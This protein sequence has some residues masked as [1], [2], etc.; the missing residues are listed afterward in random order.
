MSV[1][2]ES[3]LELTIQTT[4]LKVRN[5]ELI[6]RQSPADVTPA[7]I[8]A[9]LDSI[10]TL[11]NETEDNP[12]IYSK[13]HDFERRILVLAACYFDQLSNKEKTESF[14]EKLLIS[15]FDEVF[16][17][18]V[19]DKRIIS[20]FDAYAKQQ[21]KT[22]QIAS[23]PNGAD[24]FVNGVHVG[25]TP[26]NDFQVFKTGFDL[27]VSYRGHECYESHVD[28]SVLDTPDIHVILEL[29]SGSLKLTV[30]PE[31][32]D[33]YLND[34]YM[35]TSPATASTPFVLAAVPYGDHII[36]FRKTCYQTIRKPFTM[37]PGNWE[38]PRIEMISGSGRLQLASNH[39]V[40]VLLND[41]EA[42]TTPL[43]LD[44]LCTD[45][46]HIEVKDY[47]GHRWFQKFELRDSESVHFDIFARPTLL[48]LGHFQNEETIDNQL[49]PEI[50]HKALNKCRGFNFVNNLSDK[51]KSKHAIIS[52]TVGRS[53][54]QPYR[55]MNFSPVRT[56]I[57]EICDIENISVLGLTVKS[58]VEPNYM[59]F[60]FH[61]DIPFIET[62]DFDTCN[63]SVY[64]PP[65]TYQ[66]LNRQNRLT[67]RW[68]G[69][70]YAEINNTVIVTRMPPGSDADKA[71]LIASDR[72]ISINNNP[73]NSVRD[74]KAHLESALGQIQRI[75]IS[76]R[77]FGATRE[78][79]LPYTKS[80]NTLE[81]NHPGISY[82][83]A[84]EFF[85]NSSADADKNAALL[86]KGIA[87]LAMN[88]PQ[89]AL[90][91][92]FQPCSLQEGDGVSW[93]T[94]LFLRALAAKQL[95]HTM[96]ASQDFEL[97]A[98]G[99]ARFLDKQGPEIKCLAEYY[100]RQLR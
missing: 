45:I 59:L 61:R 51:S 6:Y 3:Y 43:E 83:L 54:Q 96:S 98:A 35:I 8:D 97:S 88:E 27:K 29:N 16:S 44:N 78:V 62:F 4:E 15:R 2:A 23:T 46:H 63:D 72:I 32:V 55:F 14:Y 11:L 64:F 71:R 93:G 80:V 39:P 7:D 74:F 50:I 1:T 40:P 70:E 12:D 76:S 68:P 10:Q 75:E 26:L 91:T 41:Q 58:D 31:S 69:F 90:Q 87:L 30:S 13:L 92:A 28:V 18:T 57:Q 20:R 42:G 38:F 85:R 19:A 79:T 60:L 82:I 33:I 67:R 73:V 99:K 49:D 89:M 34:Q 17:D 56:I 84:L 95:G 25:N 47:N 24:V 81:L 21:M 66:A 100:L 37:Q 9:L 53:L 86:N 94:V 52:E 48:Y 65:L 5:L 22:V 36:E 77:I